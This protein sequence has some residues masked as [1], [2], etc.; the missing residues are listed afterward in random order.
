MCPKAQQ[1]TLLAMP[2][3]DLAIALPFPCTGNISLQTKTKLNW[4]NLSKVYWIVTTFK[5]LSIVKKKLANVFWFKDRLIQRPF[6]LVSEVLYK[7]TWWRTYEDILG[8]RPWYLEK[9]NHRKKVQF[10]TISSFAM[11]N[12]IP[13]FDKF[14]I[15]VYEHHK[16]ILEI[17][18]RLVIKGK[19]MQIKNEIM[20]NCLRVSKVSWNFRIPTIYNFAVIYPWNVLFS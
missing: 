9:L 5:L 15:L 7:C 17:K 19:F 3:K 20:N 18:E 16:Y 12:D 2:W 13:S 1:N 10:V 4:G 14:T 8:Y 6:G 11:Y